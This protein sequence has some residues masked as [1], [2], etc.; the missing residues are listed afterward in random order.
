MRFRFK[1]PRKID[2]KLYAPGEHD[3]PESL[4][5]HPFLHGLHKAGDVEFLPDP[6]DMASDADEDGADE[7]K[8]AP[9]GLTDEPQV[10]SVPDEQDSEEAAEEPAEEPADEAAEAVE[11]AKG[12]KKKGK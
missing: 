3:L 1:H 10:P 11:P 8:D 9:E 5:E 12:K 6:A 7:S 2:G 4:S